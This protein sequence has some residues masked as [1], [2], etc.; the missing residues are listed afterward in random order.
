MTETRG[1]LL[2][3]VSSTVGK[4]IQEKWMVN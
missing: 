2:T 4:I 1:T 3:K